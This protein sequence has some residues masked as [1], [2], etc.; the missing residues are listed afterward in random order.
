MGEF[1]WYRPW[2]TDLQDSD[3]L[4]SKAKAI[5]AA[6]ATRERAGTVE[7]VLAPQ[8]R[9]APRGGQR[10]PL[11]VLASLD[12]KTARRALAELA[13][14]GW[15]DCCRGRDRLVVTLLPRSG[16][17]P[18]LDPEIG[19]HA[20]A[21]SGTTP[22]QIGHHARSRTDSTPDLSRNAAVL[23][24]DLP[25]PVVPLV[26]EG[27]V[28]IDWPAVLDWLRERVAEGAFAQYLAVLRP[29][30]RRGDRLTIVASEPRL[31]SWIEQR[32]LGLIASAVEHVVGE[33]LTIA[34]AETAADVEQRQHVAA[35]ATRRRRRDQR[36]LAE[37]GAAA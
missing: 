1:G 2:L 20:R 16:S 19:R 30:D 21:R 7:A 14:H 29:V 35:L 27:D 3:G 12:P 18:E 22:E 15:I 37:Q 23:P 4:S 31:H 25:P 34:L 36:I 8:D 28:D 9:H 32:F 6:L 13:E 10:V 17:R 33:R 26:A 24:T 5:A 11:A